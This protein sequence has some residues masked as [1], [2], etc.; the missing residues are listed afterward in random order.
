MEAS[1]V[2]RAMK[3]AICSTEAAI[4]PGLLF[5]S[6]RGSQYDSIEVRRLLKDYQVTASMSRRGNCWDNAV[7]ESFFS[8]L[9]IEEL[10]RGNIPDRDDVRPRVFDYIECFYNRSRLHSTIG[11]CSPEQYLEKYYAEQN[12][13]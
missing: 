6:D 8:S 1:L 7:A 12:A 3:N 9:K 4:L 5:H 10:Y 2:T 13:A 11:Y